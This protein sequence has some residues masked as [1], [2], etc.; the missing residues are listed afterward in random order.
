MSGVVVL[1]ATML[2]KL[3]KGVCR[4]NGFLLAAAIE[5]LAYHW[6][7]ASSSSITSVDVDPNCLNWFHFLFLVAGPVVILIGY[8]IFLLP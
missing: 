6:S 5:L 3:Q 1:I 8:N 7:V 2:D 4:T